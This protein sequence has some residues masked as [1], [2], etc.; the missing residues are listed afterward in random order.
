MMS[1]LR[2]L[3]ENWIARVLFVLLFLVFVF[4][5]ISNVVTLIGSSSAVAH[6][7]GK[8]VD[9]LLLQAE[10]Q[11]ELSAAMQNNPAQPDLATRQQIAQ[12]ALTAVL[13]Q[14]VLQAEE[15][16]LGVVVPDSVV[17]Q[18]IYG[19]PAFQTNGKFDQA[20]FTQLLQQNNSSPDQFLALV[21]RDLAGSQLVQAVTAG[22]APPQILTDQIFDF[23]SEQRS[24]EQVSIAAAAQPAPVLPP[25]A[26][27]QRYW[28]NHQAAFTAP[29]YRQAKIVILSPQT[30]APAQP[31]SDAEIQ[32]AYAS[33]YGQQRTA[34]T[35]S[36]Q[37]VSV[38]DAAS[39][40]KL[41][42]LWKGGAD[43]PALQAAAAKAGGSGVELAN[44]TPD[45]I[46]SQALADAVFAATPNAIGGPVQGAMG[47][48]V[49]N[50]TA[51][52]A[53]GAPPLAQ[54]S[55]Q[56]RQQL[57][58]QKAQAQVNQDLNNVQDALAGQTPL[59]QLPGNLGLVAVEGTL[60]ANGNTP[61]GT[62][63][64]IPGGNSLRQAIIKAIFAGHKGDAAQLI[65]GPGGGYFAFTVD[66]ITPP[67]PLPYDTVKQKVAVAWIQDAMT[68]EAEVKAAA[69]LNAV[70]NG[71]SLD[72]A[73]SAAGYSVS[74]LPPVTRNAPA[75]GTTSD[76][77]QILFSLKLGQATM[78]Q[79]AEGFS[80]AA[81]TAIIRPK[82][83]DDPSDTAQVV[84][85]MTKSLEDD[86]V[87]SF[88][89]GL[90][91]RDKVSVDNKLF[92]QVY[93]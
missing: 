90:Q 48:F 3:L 5:G 28:R 37:V 66:K 7:A 74:M 85:A 92:A 93:Q 80:I 57:Q 64:P 20:K 47:Y 26:V 87:A 63:A 6:V 77:V 76:M 8:P 84:Q 44:A 33:S 30:L 40:A 59:D 83:A 32:A 39:A 79:T 51:A 52:T 56:I 65:N 58:L 73:A 22:V 25:D 35:R 18:S 62:E 67:A 82:P 68:R 36:V 17:R 19:V 70:N 1:R 16:R 34:P 27:L 9:V 89:A 38:P 71:Q 49:F 29:E 2:K 10:Y 46:P 55:A 12:A 14:Q 69:L 23:V 78:Q 53:G 50:V 60:D 61:E 75:S 43:W 31:V 72:A 21:R 15:D 91:A 42:A 81:L 11:K 45:Q 24:A 13:R 54:V 88:I 86:T 41:A 4:W